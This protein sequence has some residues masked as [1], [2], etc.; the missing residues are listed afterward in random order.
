MT[1]RAIFARNNKDLLYL[2]QQESKE[3][4]CDMITMNSSVNLLGKRT[5]ESR[6]AAAARPEM[7]AGTSGLRKKTKVWMETPHFLQDFVQVSACPI[8]Y[9]YCVN[10]RDDGCV[11]RHVTM[12]LTAFWNANCLALGVLGIC[13]V[14]VVWRERRRKGR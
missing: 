5:V 11:Q 10:E 12:R 9:A 13:A 1:H 7:K 6:D 8:W 3:Q 14:F 2:M 4:R